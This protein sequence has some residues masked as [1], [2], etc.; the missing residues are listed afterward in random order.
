MP[1]GNQSVHQYITALAVFK[2]QPVQPQQGL[3]PVAQPTVRGTVSAV[4]CMLHKFQTV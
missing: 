2:L 1:G 4:G 3:L